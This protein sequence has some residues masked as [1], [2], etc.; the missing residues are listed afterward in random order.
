MVITNVPKAPS[1][2]DILQPID[3]RS[4]DASLH[5]AI[6]SEETIIPEIEH[7]PTKSEE[8]EIRC[9][10]SP[11]AT[12]LSQDNTSKQIQEV[13]SISQNTASTSHERKNEQGLIREMISSKEEKHVTEIS[14]NYFDE[15]LYQ[16]ACD[17]EKQAIKV[18]QDEITEGQIYDFIVAQLNAKRKTLQK[19]TQK[20]RKTYSAN[21]ISNLMAHKSKVLWIAS[22]RSFG[23]RE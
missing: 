12:S 7:N 23:D 10:A 2:K 15:N 11:S 5:N 22:H 6:A 9:S 17:A 3:L 16:K 18:N 4:E 8:S 1:T 21:T 20:A 13:P 19:Q 14:A